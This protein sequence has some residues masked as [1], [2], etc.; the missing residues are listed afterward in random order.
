M[1]PIPDE[2]IRKGNQDRGGLTTGSEPSDV[3]KVFGTDKVKETGSESEAQDD[4]MSIKKILV[5]LS[6]QYNPDDPEA[7]EKPALET[8]FTLGQRFKAHVEVFC[9]AA[10]VP[11]TQFELADW[12]PGSSVNMLIDMIE[13]ESLERRSRAISMFDKIA[14]RLSAPRIS[15]PDPEAGFCVNFLEKVGEVAGLLSHRGR[16]TD[17][18]VVACAP[19]Q[20]HGGIP[21]ML[22]VALRETGRPVFVSPPTAS[23]AFGKKI[24]IAWNGSAEAARA[25]GLAMDFLRLA[26]DVVIISVKENDQTEPSGDSLAEYLQWQGVRSQ[27]VSL[28][29]SGNSTG[30]TLLQKVEEVGADMLVMGAYTR[31]RVRRVIFG[32]VTGEVLNRMTVP[33]L[34]VD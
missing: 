25:V 22:E 34:M 7:L 27:P 13:K 28:D 17:L 2:R 14:D 11:T 8:G 16:L 18:I 9:I 12:L 3:S 30:G 23:P 20:Q 29:D 4:N 1:Q 21:P 32:G 24:A 15:R 10:D 26:H 6:G 31:D 33:V 19:L 5:P